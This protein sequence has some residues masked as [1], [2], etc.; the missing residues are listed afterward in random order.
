[1]KPEDIKIGETY[2]VRVK[3]RRTNTAGVFC[4]ACDNDG[5]YWGKHPNLFTEAEVAAFSPVTPAPKYDPCRLFRKGDRVQVKR[6]NGRCNGK[7]G[8]Y[9]REAYCLVAED[10]EKNESVRV[11]HNSSEYRLDPAYLELVTPAEELEPYEVTESTDYFAVAHRITGDEPATFWK[12][13]H[14]NPAAAAESECARLNA[15]HRKEHSHE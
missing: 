2:N 12:Q 6:R 1:M 3:V 14:P 8:E 4:Y 7:Y 11:L 5:I 10:E 15:E 13:W 9:L